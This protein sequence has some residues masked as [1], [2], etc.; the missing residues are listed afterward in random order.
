MHA[1]AVKEYGA[2]PVLVDLPKPEARAHHVVIE[3]RAAGTNPMDLK[4]AR[5]GWQSRMPGTFPLVLGSDFEGVVVGVGSGVAK[6]SPG[7][8]L[9]GQLVIPRSGRRERTRSTSPPRKM[10]RWR[11]CPPASIPRPRRRS[12][13]PARP[14]SSWSSRCRRSAVRRCSSWGRRAESDRSPRSSP[15]T[16]AR[17]SSRPR[18][19]RGRANAR[20]R[21][22]RDRRLH[23]GLTSGRG[24]T[25]SPRRD[26]RARRRGERRREICGPRVAR[27]TRWH[28][29]LDDLR[30][31]HRSA[32]SGRCH[33]RRISRSVCRRTSSRRL[34]NDVVTGCIVPPDH[35]HLAR[36]CGGRDERRAPP[37]RRQ[38][39]HHLFNMLNMVNM[40]NMRPALSQADFQHVDPATVEPLVEEERRALRRDARVSTFIDILAE[41]RVGSACAARQGATAPSLRRTATAARRDGDGSGRRLVVAADGRGAPCSA[42][43]ELPA[44]VGSRCSGAPFLVRLLWKTR[45]VAD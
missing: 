10:H 1:I 41:R 13:R 39:R 32:R 40:V 18:G 33:R 7:D 20:I 23:R 2:Q 24:A 4:I 35:P 43:G 42:P 21:R 8:E 36:R 37:R 27:S 19:P 22:G 45:N 16:P 6:F 38:D 5:G 31:R 14:R 25:G 3:V 15:P 44:G 17:T 28:R 34:A 26:R 11:E 9:F 12:P 29:G 30:R